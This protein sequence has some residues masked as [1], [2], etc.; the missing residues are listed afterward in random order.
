MF[1]R[2]ATVMVALSCAITSSAD[3]PKRLTELRQRFQALQHPTEVD[4]VR[5][6]TALVRLRE[7]LT[8]ADSEKMKAIDSEI[9][10]YPI[11][12]SADSAALRKR[13]LGHWTS[14]R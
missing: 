11:P 4:R 13:I 12:D 14:P 5:Y 9:I 6:I 10:K 1:T 7:S 3:E 2:V 8:R